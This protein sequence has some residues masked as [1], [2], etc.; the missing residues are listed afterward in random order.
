MKL[1]KRSKH[2]IVRGLSLHNTISSSLI[3]STVISARA[4]NAAD[5]LQLDLAH[6]SA[7]HSA[8]NGVESRGLRRL[9]SERS[10]CMDRSAPIGLQ[11]LQRSRRPKAKAPAHTATDKPAPEA[12][13]KG[14]AAPDPECVIQ[15]PSSENELKDGPSF[16]FLCLRVSTQSASAA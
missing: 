1:R 11:P 2:R 4:R 10:G 8:R 15:Q 3:K 16:P 14:Q 12:L 6:S 7:A 13:A 5:D 9:M